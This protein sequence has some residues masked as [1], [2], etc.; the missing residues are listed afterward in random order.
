MHR[1][2]GKGG[3]GQNAFMTSHRRDVDPK[4]RS[5]L[6]SSRIDCGPRLSRPPS[7]MKARVFRRKH[8]LSPFR[9]IV[10]SGWKMDFPRR[11]DRE[12]APA[13]YAI[14]NMGWTD[15]DI[16]IF[17]DR[18]GWDGDDF[19]PR[20]LEKGKIRMKATVAIYVPRIKSKGR[21]SLLFLV[22]TDVRRKILER[23]RNRVQPDKI[24]ESGIKSDLSTDLEVTMIKVK[25]KGPLLPKKV[26]GRFTLFTTR[27]L[28]GK[29]KY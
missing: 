9:S 8:T 15:W 6:S 27:K 16:C 25:R 2:R 21:F 29:Q 4:R 26:V 12:N 13:F 5:R 23:C 3:S 20:F 24:C 1:R 14:R 11:G 18:R 7:G 17:M 19:P 10:V 28:A 22:W